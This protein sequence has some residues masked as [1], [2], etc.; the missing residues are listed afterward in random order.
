MAFTMHPCVPSWRSSRGFLK[1]GDQMD[2]TE[3]LR[4]LQPRLAAHR[5]DNKRRTLV[6]PLIAAL[7]CAGGARAQLIPSPP[8]QFDT[9]GF[10]QSATIDRSL[11]PSVSDPLLWG[12]TVMINGIK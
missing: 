12:G 4:G 5:F 2:R 9:L 1:R 10:I 7:L 11:C 6:G 3:R 8:A